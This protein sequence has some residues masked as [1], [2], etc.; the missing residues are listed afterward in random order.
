MRFW[1]ECIE[2]ISLGV[3]AHS[4][5]AR[6]SLNGLDSLQLFGVKDLHNARISNRNIDGAPGQN[7]AH[8]APEEEL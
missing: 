6:L 4:V 1:Q 3:E 5:R 7:R 8:V 2:L